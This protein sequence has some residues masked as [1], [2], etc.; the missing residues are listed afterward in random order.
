MSN[1]KEYRSVKDFP[2]NAKAEKLTK[3]KLLTCYQDLRGTYKSLTQSRG[4]L[5]RRQE[6]AKGKIQILNQGIQEKEQ[7]IQEQDKT[8]QQQEQNIQEQDKTIQQQEQNIQE[9]EQKLTKVSQ[10]LDTAILSLNQKSEDLNQK[11]QELQMIQ[12]EFK[13]ISDALEKSNLKLKR[14]EQE[15]N[16]IQNEINQLQAER[17]AV[18]AMIEDL[19]HTYQAVQKQEGLIGT[20]YRLNDIMRAVFKLLN[21]D[22]GELIKQQKQQIEQD[23]SLKENPRNLGRNLLDNK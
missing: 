11:Q 14:T 22:I 15:R 20:V 18:S 5:V 2:D 17:R 21:T 23:Q 9:Q 19:N 8:I 1:F 16:H 3:Q 12:Q 10:Q 4:Q 6:E 7:N 13:T